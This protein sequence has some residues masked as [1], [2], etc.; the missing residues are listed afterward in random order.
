MVYSLY[1]GEPN[2]KIFATYV[3]MSHGRALR[4]HYVVLNCS[5]LISTPHI[6]LNPVEFD[7][8]S[9]DSILIPNKCTV[10]IQEVH[11]Y[12]WLQEKMH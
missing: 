9:V 8:N 7:W 10:T 6:N 3:N 11:C 2:V 4:S 5:K 12:L 1:K